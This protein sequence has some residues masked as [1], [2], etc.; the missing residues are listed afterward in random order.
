MDVATYKKGIQT[1][2][3]NFLAGSDR[4]TACFRK[5]EKN[6]FP[7]DNTIQASSNWHPDCRSIPDKW[8]CVRLHFFQSLVVRSKILHLF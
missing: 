1:L 4:S 2:E 6:R 7:A 3:M 5:F 8:L